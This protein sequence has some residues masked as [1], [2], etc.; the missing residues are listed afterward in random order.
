MCV[1]MREFV[2]V[3]VHACLRGCLFFFVRECEHVCV[4]MREFVCVSVRSYV[5]VYVFVC[6]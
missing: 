3:S 6:V 1:C 5:V 2:C 4:C